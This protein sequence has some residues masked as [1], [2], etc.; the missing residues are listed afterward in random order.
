M[1]LRTSTV[2]IL[3]LEIYAAVEAQRPILENVN[4]QPLEVSRGVDDADV[5]GLHEI[6]RHDD[7]L[8]V[9]RDLCCAGIFVRK[10]SSL[11]TGWRDWGRD[12]Y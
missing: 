1:R 11:G 4:V 6:V 12:T 8:L 10:D 9:G 5:T 2:F 7:V 3:A